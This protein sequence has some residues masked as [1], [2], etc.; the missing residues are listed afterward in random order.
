MLPSRSK[1]IELVM[2]FLDEDRQDGRELKDIAAELV[3]GYLEAIRGDIEPGWSALHEGMA[4][5]TS[6]WSGVSYVAWRG[7]TPRGERVWIVD[8]GCSYGSF[9]RPDAFWTEFVEESTDN[10]RDK[11]KPRPGSPGN[12]P[13]WKVGDK[14]R[15]GQHPYVY[16]VVATGDKCV[17]LRDE[18]RGGFQP[19]SNS[20]MSKYYRRLVL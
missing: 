8:S 19:E 13:V 2:S 4:F 18:S 15:R 14:A 20:G 7:Q 6:L 1:Q 9:S 12:N 17:L 3:D 10:R 5:K 16:E 11:S